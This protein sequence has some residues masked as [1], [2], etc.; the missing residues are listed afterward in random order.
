MIIHN[1]CYN[2]IKFNIILEK[3]QKLEKTHFLPLFCQKHFFC[4]QNANPAIKGSGLYKQAAFPSA[5]QWTISEIESQCVVMSW[6]GSACIDLHACKPGADQWARHS[7]INNTV[8]RAMMLMSWTHSACI[9]C[10]AIHTWDSADQIV[11]KFQIVCTPSARYLTSQRNKYEIATH[12]GNLLG[13]RMLGNFPSRDSRVANIGCGI[14]VSNCHVL[15]N[16][17]ATFPRDDGRSIRSQA[18]LQS[19]TGSF[20]DW[21]LVRIIALQTVLLMMLWRAHLSAPG[22]QACKSM[23]AE[24]VHDITTHTHTHTQ[25]CWRNSGKPILSPTAMHTSSLSKSPQFW[26]GMAFSHAVTTHQESSAF[27]YET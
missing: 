19:S 13:R 16:I 14:S 22:L 5:L 11:Q 17:S 4:R 25:S 26:T 3:R 20:T 18:S 2:Y 6:T 8:W 9:A 24:R 21:N 27:K 1:K 7:I 10:I 23:Q 12:I 15:C